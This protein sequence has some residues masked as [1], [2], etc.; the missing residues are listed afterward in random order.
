MLGVTLI[1]PNSVLGA[2]G[3]LHLNSGSYIHL[4]KPLSTA[5]GNPP[6]FSSHYRTFIPKLV[7]IIRMQPVSSLDT[8]KTS[9]LFSCPRLETNSE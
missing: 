7:V 2:A 8:A 4:Y 5:N 1:G 6:Q 3:E 9:S